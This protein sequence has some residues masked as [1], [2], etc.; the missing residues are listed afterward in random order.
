MGKTS[1][2]ANI[3]IGLSPIILALPIPA[4][5]S[6]RSGLSLVLAT[7]VMVFGF[8]AFAVA[9]LARFRSGRW[10]SFGYRGMPKWGRYSYIGGLVAVAFGAVGSLT[11][12]WLR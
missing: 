11:T 1:A 2:I 12:V 8:I 9:K 3:L 6:F 7:F 4:F 5:L 10:F